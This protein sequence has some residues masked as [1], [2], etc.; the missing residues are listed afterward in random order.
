MGGQFPP[1][2]DHRNRACETAAAGRRDAIENR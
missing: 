2:T 1:V